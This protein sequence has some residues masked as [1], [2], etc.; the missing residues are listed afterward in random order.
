MWCIV[1]GEKTE[2]MWGGFPDVMCGGDV[3]RGLR[4]V[5]VHLKVPSR[6]SD[7]CAENW[8]LC[9]SQQNAGAPT[10]VCRFCGYTCITCTPILLPFSSVQ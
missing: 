3:S 4:V 1:A 2:N 6:F 10:N 5:Q 8:H 7:L 9:C